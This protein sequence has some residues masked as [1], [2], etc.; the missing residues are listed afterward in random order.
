MAKGLAEYRQGRFKDAIEILDPLLKEM[1]EVERTGRKTPSFDACHP[2]VCFISAMAHHELNDT[3]QAGAAMDQGHEIVRIKF[4]AL[5]G[6]RFGGDWMNTLMS[7]TLMSEADK[8][9]GIAFQPQTQVSQPNTDSK[10][11][12]DLITPI[13]IADLAKMPQ[14]YRFGDGDRLRVWQRIDEQIWHEVYP[15]G[16]TSVF[17]VVGRTTVGQTEGTVVVKTA[18]DPNRTGAFND[19]TLQAFIPDKGSPVMHHWFRFFPGDKW[20]DLAPMR[21]IQ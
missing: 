18:G 3:E 2:D 9:V 5:E 17:K 8:T 11:E 1:D 21:D 12:I 7:Y 19:G 14:S 16:F 15:D 13:M 10:A 4:P 6:K 20:R